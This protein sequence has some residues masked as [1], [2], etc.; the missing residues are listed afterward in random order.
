LC[1]E[2]YPAEEPDSPSYCISN[3]DLANYDAANPLVGSPLTL[4]GQSR[5]GFGLTVPGYMTDFNFDTAWQSAPGLTY[6][7]I[8]VPFGGDKQVQSVS[9]Y[10]D[11]LFAY[12]GSMAVSV[13][14]Q[15]SLTT[16]TLLQYLSD[17]CTAVS[18]QTNVTCIEQNS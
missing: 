2:E 9:V 14:K 4:A 8:T 3:D 16:L 10:F 6:A 12:Q 5:F 18:S 1:S 13:A 17:N 11:S 7:T 15:P